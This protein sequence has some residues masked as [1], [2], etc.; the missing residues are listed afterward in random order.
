[1]SITVVKATKKD[2]PT[3]YNLVK[4]LAKYENALHEVTIDLDYYLN[5]FS[6]DIFRC[7]VAKDKDEIVGTCI[8]YLTYSTWKGKMMYLEDFVVRE[9]HRKKGIGQLLFDEF[10]K[11][12]KKENCTMAKW[13]VL[14]WN[15]PAIK[16]YNKNLATIEKDWWNCK[17]IF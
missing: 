6:N 5:S 7:I 15:E 11:Q 14:D 2:I 12:S 9:E 16:F 1:M 13:Q 4:E 8:Y 17:I 10:I 3:V